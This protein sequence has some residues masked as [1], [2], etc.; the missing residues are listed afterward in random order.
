MDRWLAYEIIT[1][2]GRNKR[3]KQKNDERV[4]TTRH[5]FENEL[6][7]YYSYENI[8]RDDNATKTVLLYLRRKLLFYQHFFRKKKFKSVNIQANRPLVVGFKTV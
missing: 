5:A 3:E 6:G 2:F 4:T 8:T 7:D 1:R